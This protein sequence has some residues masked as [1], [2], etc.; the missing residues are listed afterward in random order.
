MKILSK[1]ENATVTSKDRNTFGRIFSAHIA[2]LNANLMKY[3]IRCLFKPLP[4]VF[5]IHVFALRGSKL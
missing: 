4:Y 3:V 5:V 2:C 1:F